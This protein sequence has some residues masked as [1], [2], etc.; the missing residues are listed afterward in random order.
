MG[1]DYGFGSTNIDP[2]TK[3]RYGIISMYDVMQAW[4]DSDEPYYPCDE[5]DVYK[6]QDDEECIDCEPST[7]YIDDG[8][9]KAELCFDGT[10]IMIMKSPYFTA[11]AY[12]SPCAPGAINLNQPENPKTK[13]ADDIAYCFGHDWFE[14]GKAPYRVFSVE[15]GKEVLP[16]GP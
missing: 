11:G 7:W 8:E 9:Y 12:C 13:T 10:E 1:I 6:K 3:I 4:C 16:D 14:D 2:K 5:C 15:T